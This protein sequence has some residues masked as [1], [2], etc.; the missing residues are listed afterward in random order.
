MP[1][2]DD[3]LSNDYKLRVSYDGG[4]AWV[5]EGM[6]EREA[7][8]IAAVVRERIRARSWWD[9]EEWAHPSAKHER[10]PLEIGASRR[11]RVFVVGGVL[12]AFVAIIGKSLANAFRHPGC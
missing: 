5:G 10:A 12:L 3:A 2:H 7:E 9:D 1:Q 6:G 11:A 4:T 8:D